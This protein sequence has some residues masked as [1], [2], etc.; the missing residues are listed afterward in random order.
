MKHILIQLLSITLLTGGCKT[1]QP[2]IQIEHDSIVYINHSTHDS[3]YNYVHDSTT[4]KQKGD[5]IYK[6][7]YHTVIKYKE[8][9]KN[10]STNNKQYFNITKTLSITTNKL[11]T[12]Q[13]VFIYIGVTSLL[14]LIIGIY[15]KI[16]K[17]L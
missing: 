17:V 11:N 6:D 15:L 3:I 14:L 12:I 10:D 9:N 5:T 1:M 13:K 16:K 8:I 2:S 4:I 7:S